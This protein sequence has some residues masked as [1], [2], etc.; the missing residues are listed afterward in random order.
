MDWMFYPPKFTYD[1]LTSNVMVLGSGA[2]GRWLGL[3]FTRVEPHN[4][5]SVHI[6]K[7]R[8][9]KPLPL[10]SPHKE[11]VTVGT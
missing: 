4:K 6:R 2:F 8:D 7:R 11:E 1:I 10:P 3:E 5:I 9:M